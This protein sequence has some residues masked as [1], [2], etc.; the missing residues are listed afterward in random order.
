MRLIHRI[1][2]IAAL[3]GLFASTAAHAQQAGCLT[4]SE[5]NSL[6]T[7]SLPVVMDSAMKTCRPA[8]SPKGYF[9][10]QGSSLVQSYAARK[11]AAWPAAKGALMKIGG[12]DPK[13]KDMVSRLPDSALQP[14][15]EGMVAQMVS[16]GLKTDQCAAIERATR[17]LAPLPPEN[18]ADLITFVIIM[19]DKPKAGR[20]TNLPLCPVKS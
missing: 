17:L 6:V 7:Y 15:A 3:T 20:T 1:A 9:A 13:M 16:D 4:E 12:Q 5:L 10:T 8:L 11:D 14:F 18:T 2:G 19:A